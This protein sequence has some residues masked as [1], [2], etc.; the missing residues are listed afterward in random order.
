[1]TKLIVSEVGEV[2]HILTNGTA[3]YVWYAD[4]PAAVRF[5]VLPENVTTDDLSGVLTYESIVALPTGSVKEAGYVQLSDFDDAPCLY[6]EAEDTEQLRFWVNLSSGLLCRAESLRGGA[7]EYELRQTRLLLLDDE[8]E[9][10]KAQM[11]LPDG[12]EP[13][14]TEAE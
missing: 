11:L 4:D 3:A 2:R 7:T 6:V 13:T 5:S 12:K 9:N 10:L 1:M 14:F 8:D